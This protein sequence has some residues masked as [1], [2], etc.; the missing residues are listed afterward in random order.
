MPTKVII[1]I[2]YAVYG[3]QANTVDVTKQVQNA[4]SGD[5]LTISSKRLGIENPAPNET[6]HFAVKANITIDNNEPYPFYYI[7]KDYET[8]DFIP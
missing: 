5:D 1:E 4:L 6:K 2:E 3:N 8:I 7:A